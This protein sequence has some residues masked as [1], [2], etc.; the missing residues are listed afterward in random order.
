MK[1]TTEYPGVTTAGDDHSEVFQVSRNHRSTA[2]YPGVTV[3]GQALVQ[4]RRCQQPANA[5]ASTAC[6]N[7]AS[8]GGDEGPDSFEPMIYSGSLTER[9]IL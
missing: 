7:P 6:A 2:E 3:R 8:A 9:L 1:S 5:I 4:D